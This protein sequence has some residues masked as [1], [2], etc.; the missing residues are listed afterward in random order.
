VTEY[1]TVEQFGY[2]QEL[3][4]RLS[5]VDMGGLRGRVGHRARFAM[6]RVHVRPVASRSC[7]RWVGST[8]RCPQAR[9][10]HGR[11]PDLR[12]G[13]GY[14]TQYRLPADCPHPPLHRDMRGDCYD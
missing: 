10:D 1:V 11:G 7:P 8:R 5:L 14:H 12:S 4:R 3:V 2:R 13:A 6:M 9:H